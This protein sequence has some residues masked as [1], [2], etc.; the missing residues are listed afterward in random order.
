[1]SRVVVDASV[2]LAWAFPDE[3]NEYADAVLLSLEG[4]AVLVPAIWP[5]EIANA[6]VVAER[7]GR[8]TPEDIGRFIRTLE[9]LPIRVSL[10]S[11]TQTAQTTL[12]LARV[13]R[14]S[15]YDA[16]HLELAMREKAPL[17]TLDRSLRR[18]ALAEGTVIHGEGDERRAE[19]GG[20]HAR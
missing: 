12:P 1:M 9:A 17:A 11:V 5:L 6:L 15:A 2:A 20:D 7:R 8:L 16:S 19:R 13:H 14:L 3:G 4:N 18:A 10:Q